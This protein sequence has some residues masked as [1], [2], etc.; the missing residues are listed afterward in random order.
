MS[1]HSYQPDGRERVA[2]PAGEFDA[3]KLVRRNEGSGETAEVWFA[4]DRA[5]LPVRI[6]LVE[7]DGTRYEHRAKRISP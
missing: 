2:T 4:A 1:R 7:K 5:P 6:V 3:V